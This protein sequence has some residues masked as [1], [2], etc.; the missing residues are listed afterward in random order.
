MNETIINFKKHFNN[1][2]K[3]TWYNYDII[4]ND[5]MPLIGK[6]KDENILVA[7]AF[8]KWGMTNGILAAKIMT[9]AARHLMRN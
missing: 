7:T 3:N 2:I 5:H 4:S 1:K 6:L 8:N 9:D